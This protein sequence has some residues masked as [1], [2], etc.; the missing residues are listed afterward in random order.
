M[1]SSILPKNERKQFNLR[2][3]SSKVEFIRSFFGRIEDTKKTFRNYLTF[4]TEP[5]L[6][7]IVMWESRRV[8]RQFSC[9]RNSDLWRNWYLKRGDFQR[10]FP[11]WDTILTNHWFVMF[12]RY[13]NKVGLLW[14]W[15]N[16][17][18]FYFT[19]IIYQNYIEVSK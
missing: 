12:D 10:D 7:W 15:R 16:K 5:F 18:V 14:D 3:H 13:A 19:F 9:K 4:T 11:A 8:S 6:P 1:L 17:S 2:Y